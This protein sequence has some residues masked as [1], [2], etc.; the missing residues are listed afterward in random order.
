MELQVESLLSREPA[1]GGESLSREPGA[2]SSGK[3]GKAV[4]FPRGDKG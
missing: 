2:V 4:K 1:A 3:E